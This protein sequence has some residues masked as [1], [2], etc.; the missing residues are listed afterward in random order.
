VNAPQAAA[1]NFESTSYTYTGIYPYYW[2]TSVTLPTTSTIADE[3]SGGTANKVL[4]SASG[5]ITI[6][7]SASSEYLWFAHFENYTTKTKWFVTEFNQGAIGGGSN[8]FNT[9]QIVS[10]DSFDGYW[11]TI[12]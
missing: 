10:V 2:G 3:I 9:P 8:L 11:N 12:N 5:T 1:N 4:S 6:N 7:F